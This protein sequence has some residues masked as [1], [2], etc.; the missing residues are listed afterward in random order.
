MKEWMVDTIVGS[1][2]LGLV[3]LLLWLTYSLLQYLGFS[4][5]N[6]FMLLS[7]VGLFLLLAHSFGETLR[8]NRRQK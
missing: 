3:F 8:R 6:V 7:G 5:F 2:G 1:A 4:V